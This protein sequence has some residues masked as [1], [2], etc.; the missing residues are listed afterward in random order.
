MPYKTQPVFDP[1]QPPAERITIKLLP[2]E[3]KGVYRDLCRGIQ[4]AIR[5]TK[6]SAPNSCE[7]DY[8][9]INI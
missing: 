5:K 3:S 1:N 9:R 8:L 2:K 6:D 4:K 7:T